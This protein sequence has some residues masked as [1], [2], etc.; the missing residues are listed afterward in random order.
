LGAVALA[1]S[2]G[3]RKGFGRR[4]EKGEKRVSKIQR[5]ST[6]Q[7]KKLIFESWGTGEFGTKKGSGD[8]ARKGK[9][10]QQQKRPPRLER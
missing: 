2:R 5:R 6:T 7:R 9:Q 3:R 1:S 10:Q 4:E 8:G